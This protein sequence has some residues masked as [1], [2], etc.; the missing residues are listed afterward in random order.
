[1]YRGKT[2]WLLEPH[3][4][5][6]RCRRSN[7]SHGCNTESS[8]FVSRQLPP[9]LRGPPSVALPQERRCDKHCDI[10]H[11]DDISQQP[12]MILTHTLDV[13]P[14]GMSPLQGTLPRD[15][16]EGAAAR[17]VLFSRRQPRNMLRKRASQDFFTPRQGGD[18]DAHAKKRRH[19]SRFDQQRSANS[20][21]DNVSRSLDGSRS[22]C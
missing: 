13:A 5:P 20:P 6:P 14:K 1:M 12:S 10:D 18:A 11:L 9:P 2:G 8:S 3:Q 21:R 16:R 4:R 7:L 22:D 15:R 19:R 17:E